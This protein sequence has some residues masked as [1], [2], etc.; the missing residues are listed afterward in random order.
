VLIRFKSGRPDYVAVAYR[1]R[2]G[3][4]GCVELIDPGRVHFGNRLT[5]NAILRIVAANCPVDLAGL[6][7]PYARKMPSASP[8]SYS[9]TG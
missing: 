3:G 9:E 8:E 2:C 4:V 7:V 5:E 1:S 6:I